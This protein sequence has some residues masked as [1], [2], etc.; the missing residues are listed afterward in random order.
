MIQMYN[1]WV[2]AIVCGEM[3]SMTLIDQLAAFDCVDHGI[4]KDKLQLD[5][6]DETALGWIEDYLSNR[7]QSCYVESFCLRCWLSRWVYHKV[8]SSAP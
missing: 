4:L 7:E 1:T 3:A 6:F 2:E 5:G 8:L